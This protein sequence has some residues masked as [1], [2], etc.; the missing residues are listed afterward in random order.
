M[1][2]KKQKCCCGSTKKIPCVCMIIGSE[3]S[4]SNPKC[5]CFKLLSKQM[6]SLKK[7]KTKKRKRKTKG[8]ER[9]G[10]KKKIDHEGLKLLDS[11]ELVEDYEIWKL[12]KQSDIFEDKEFIRYTTQK[13][14]QYFKNLKKHTVKDLERRTEIMGA[15]RSSIRSIIDESKSKKDDLI[16]LMKDNLDYSDIQMK[17]YLSKLRDFMNHYQT[18]HISFWS[19]ICRGRVGNIPGWIQAHIFSTD[20]TGIELTDTV[21]THEYIFYVEKSSQELKGVLVY[22]LKQKKTKEGVS[23]HVLEIKLICANKY[24]EG[25]GSKI[26][27]T[28][29][30]FGE[31]IHNLKVIIIE[32]TS[33]AISFYK[34]MGYKMKSG[35]YNKIIKKKGNIIE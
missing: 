8:E 35:Y 28:L 22:R 17:M 33:S 25:L 23:F 3:C 13:Y 12:D 27:K 14:N 15:E 9:A 30:M 29:F 24:T 6:R 20:P 21:F 19:D 5:P 26:M 7:K 32:P 2:L 1:K 4:S 16:D 31:R 34:K 11:P 10:L 18:D